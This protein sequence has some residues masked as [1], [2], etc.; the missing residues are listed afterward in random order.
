MPIEIGWALAAPDTGMIRVEAHLIRPD[1]HWSIGE[2]WDETAA[3]L[4]GIGLTQLYAEGRSPAE[5]LQRMNEVLGGRELYSD[6]PGWD[7][8]WLRMIVDTAGVNPSFS[9]GLVEAHTLIG[10]VAS[11]QGWEPEPCLAVMDEIS[12]DHPR[13]HRAAADAHHLAALWLAMRQGPNSQM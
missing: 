4:H 1:D 3:Q 2:K 9:V 11:A 6:A 12:R 5:I 13:T 8:N 10:A 7:G